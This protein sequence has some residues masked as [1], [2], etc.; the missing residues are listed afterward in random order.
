MDVRRLP[1]LL[2][3]LALA[4]CTLFTDPGD[5]RAA[6]GVASAIGDSAV[7]SLQLRRDLAAIAWRVPKTERVGRITA[8]VDGV[9]AE[10]HAFVLEGVLVPSADPERRAS[11]RC[12]WSPVLL[13]AWRGD[14]VTDGFVIIGEDF[15]AEVSPRP[16]FR[17]SWQ[18]GTEPRRPWGP[19]VYVA[20]PGAATQAWLG[21][22]G[23]VLLQPERTGGACEALWANWIWNDDAPCAEATYT[24]RAAVTLQESAPAAGAELPTATVVGSG[25]AL[26]VVGGSVPGKRLTLRC[27]ALRAP[28]PMTDQ[29]CG[30]PPGR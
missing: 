8:V 18:T 9:R 1:I 22:G 10:Y 15:T 12:P 4:G 21:V 6:G 30:A 2:L 20:R 11:A 17:C 29:H 5:P 24:V 23:T 27:D 25:R 7:S 14:P 13:F 28:H 26:Y 3:L 16:N 19:H